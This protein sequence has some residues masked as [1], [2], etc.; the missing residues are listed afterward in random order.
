[1]T[2]APPPALALR[3]SFASAL[4]E[5]AQPWEAAPAPD[6]R[7]VVVNAA[8]AAELGLPPSWLDGEQ[9]AN[10]FTGNDLHGG[11]TA[12]AQAYAGHQFG[13]YVPRLGDGRAL[14]LGELRH[15]DGRWRD[16]HLKGSG[17]T[18][19]SRGGDGFAAVGPMLREFLISEALHHLGIPTTRSL[20]VVGTGRTIRR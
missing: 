6:P 1:M 4:P 5:L 9:A 10:F 13:V 20:A 11:A 18:P 8:L 16:I 14:L 2:L 19:F 7:V 12:V 3:D 17:P 15:A